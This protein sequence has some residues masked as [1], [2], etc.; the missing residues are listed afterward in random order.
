MLHTK[1][2]KNLSELTAS[3][4]ADHKKSD[5]FTNYISVLKLGKLHGIFQ[6]VKKKGIPSL[7]LVD[8][9]ICLPFIERKN[10]HRFIGSKW[11]SF[12][13]YG[14]DAYYRLKK[15]PKINWRNFHLGVVKQMLLTVPKNTS[16]N[17][18]K[19]FIFDDTPIL[20]TGHKIEGV[21]K[22]WNHVIGRSILG[23]QLLVMGYYDGVLFIPIDF[24]FHREKGR[25]GKKPYG[26]KAKHY[27]E[28]SK[29]KICKK[30]TGFQR[31]KE[32]NTSKIASSVKMLKRAVKKEIIADY[33]LTDSWFTCWEMVKTAVNSKLK[34]IGMFSK[35]KTKFG[36]RSKKMTYKE[37]RKYNRKQTKRNKKFNLYYI[38]TVVEWNET[39]VV[40]YFTR[41]GR[42]GNWKVLLSTD[43]SGNFTK[44][45]ETY[46]LRWSIEVFFKESK[47]LLNLGKSQSTDFD[48]QLA[49]TTIVMVQYIF[50][51]IKK[52]MESYQTLGKLF[53]NTKAECLEIKLHQRLIALLI[54]IVAI[55]EELLAEVDT[56]KMI[57][58]MINKPEYLERLKRILEPNHNIETTSKVA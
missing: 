15:N 58:K 55:I 4:C 50:L 2:I 9:L 54:A 44:T 34:Y 11:Q 19:A 27:R 7:L 24:S 10:V 6:S 43:L 51:S 8:V 35:V 17:G 45:A 31:R 57:I 48:A 29:K 37:I 53:E 18:V 25:N 52:R 42:N 39:L 20:K 46:Q 21:S 1:D 41:K 32:L 56:Q 5:F 28:Q 14:K 26:L 22:V 12:T 16:K 13:S 33:V 38:R 30:S 47:Q 49:D 23:Y 40:L 3:F 36:F